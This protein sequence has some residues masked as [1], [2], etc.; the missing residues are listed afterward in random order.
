MRLIHYLH[1]R[2]YGYPSRGHVRLA[3]QQNLAN[4]SFK[5]RLGMLY[6]CGESVEEL[7]KHFTIPRERVRMTLNV[8]VL[9]V[10]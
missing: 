8:I 7:A 3:L 2:I 9:G 4:N 5:W 6:V 1:K 10:K